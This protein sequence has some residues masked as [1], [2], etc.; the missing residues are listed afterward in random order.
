MEAASRTATRTDDV[1]YTFTY[2]AD[3]GGYVGASNA[4]EIVYADC[5][6]AHLMAQYVANQDTA[7]RKGRP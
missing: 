7:T 6:E 1:A 4:A 5:D 2:Y 3:G